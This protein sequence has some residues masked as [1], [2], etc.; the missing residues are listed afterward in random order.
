M[1]NKY[2]HILS[3]IDRQAY[4]KKDGHSNQLTD[5]QIER[6][7]QINRETDTQKSDILT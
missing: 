2:K 4:N 7:T 5:R 6:K 1:A 3:Q